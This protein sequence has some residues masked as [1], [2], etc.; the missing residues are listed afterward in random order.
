MIAKVSALPKG[1]PKKT[2]SLCPEC[3]RIIPATIFESDGK[4][5]MEKNA[6]SMER[7]RTYTGRTSTCT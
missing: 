3:K 2:E 1:L 5:L 4:V 6:R 7:S